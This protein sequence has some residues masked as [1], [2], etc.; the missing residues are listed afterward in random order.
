MVA[1]A[2]ANRSNGHRQLAYLSGLL[3]GTL[4]EDSIF[5]PISWNSDKSRPP[6]K[7]FASAET[8]ATAEAIDE[9]NV[10]PN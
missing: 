2:D 7:P 4:S 10:L 5:H 3:F 6:T 8:L 9:G 1:F